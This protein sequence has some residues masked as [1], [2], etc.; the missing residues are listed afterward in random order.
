MPSNAEGN[1]SLGYDYGLFLYA[2]SMLK[3]S[4]RVP[5]LAAMLEVLDETGAW[6][7][8]YDNKKP[9]N[10]RCRPWESAINIDA[11][12]KLTESFQ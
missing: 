8:Y 9:F 10:C 6:V 1:R 5:A 12:R 2:M 7:E 3:H 4:L 11:I